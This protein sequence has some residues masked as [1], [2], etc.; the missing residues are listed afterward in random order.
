MRV[1]K[2]CI[3]GS[4]GALGSRLTTAWNRIGTSRSIIP[5]TRD[6]SISKQIVNCQFVVVATKPN[7]SRTVFRELSTSL[8]PGQMLISTVAG[9][10][11]EN[12]FQM[13]NGFPN[14]ACMMPNLACRM[15][16]SHTIYSVSEQT[17]P[18][19]IYMFD[20]LDILSDLGSFDECHSSLLP[21]TCMNPGSGPGFMQV[22]INDFI[23]AARR[24]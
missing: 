16:K 9:T 2:I 13:T 15:A 6:M 11:P 24:G 7:E 12:V 18:P 17:R 10:T 14:I 3:I 20:F 23:S 22:I 19:L 21:L 4:D 8:C 5:C 1:I